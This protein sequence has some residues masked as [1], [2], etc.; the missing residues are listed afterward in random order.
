MITRTC[1][2]IVARLTVNR[3]I[4]RNCF[5]RAMSTESI[6]I[7]LFSSGVR[8]VQPKNLFRAENVTIN[9][10]EST[11]VCKF[12]EHQVIIDISRNK[13]CHLVGFG[14]GVYGMA[15]EL[16]KLLGERLKSGIISVPMNIQKTFSDV[17]LPAVVRVFEGAKNNLPD[18][19]AKCAAI[20]I[21][22]L[23]KKMIADDILFVLI[24][25]GGSALLPLPRT[26]VALS[27][28]S[29]LI[30]QMAGKGAKITE[31]NRVRSDLSETKGGQLAQYASNADAVVAFIISDIIGDPLHLIASG[32]TV[33][34]ADC[35]PDEESSIDILKR[36]DLWDS[37]PEHIA[38]I[39]SVQ[40]KSAEHIRF[41]K[42]VHNM[43]IANNE[44]AVNAV[45]QEV[46]AKN[47]L[48][49]ILSTAIEGTVADLSKAYFELSK[50]IQMY[51]HNQINENE[52]LQQLNK[53]QSVLS[54][55]DSFLANISNVVN[56]SKNNSIDL[57]IIGGGEP[58]VQITGDGV[59]GR[60]QE[61]ALRFTAL[62]VED[63]LLQNVYLLSGGT[64][65]IDGP[66]NCAGAIGGDDIF[67]NYLMTTENALD[68][69]N[70]FIE[71]NDSYSFYSSLSQGKYHI[72]CG[73]TGTNVM[74]LHLL[75]FKQSRKC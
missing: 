23:A 49:I 14:K 72:L 35:F 73:H 36:F 7:D 63:R 34:S 32:P 33:R 31:I 52:F 67:R 30:K 15:N 48:G 1:R 54:I 42:N 62:S 75:Y 61:L 24:T 16:S 9:S 47:L 68:N 53:L 40:S 20:E 25:G 39:L 17:Q 26:G 13:R 10:V 56:E 50:S 5:R 37:L 44:V 29:S 4:V 6:L 18:K 12:N 38:E 57:C 69:I 3:I 64:D 51:M 27:E 8:S 28:K 45:L 66:T 70:A 19:H 22:E 58:T 74:D 2:H 46:T 59:G 71:N 41:A 60:N 43:L 11:I 55:R 65:G 21:V